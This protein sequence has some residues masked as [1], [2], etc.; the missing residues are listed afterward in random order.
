[1]SIQLL[2]DLNEAQKKAVLATEGPL[3]IL[4]GAGSG[5][6]RVLT[7][8]VAYL[9]LEK[10]VDPYN[11]LMVTFT[12]KAAGE[13]KKRIQSLVGE[14]H[15]PQS[16]T[17]HAFAAKLLRIEGN[18][19]GI[20]KSFS[21]YDEQDQLEAIKRVLVALDISSKNFHPKSLANTISQAKNELINAHEYVQYARG[22]FQETASRVYLAYQE[23][24]KKNQALDFDD[25][26]LETVR[27]LREVPTVAQKYQERFHYVLVDE[28]QD[29]N[30]AQY[31]ITRLLSKKHRNVCIVGDASQS[32]YSWRGANFRNIMNFQKDFPGTK[33][34]HLEQN[35]RSTQK[36]IDA[37]Y[38]VISFNTSHPVLKLWTDNSQGDNII[39]YEARNEQ[40]EAVFI[41]NTINHLLNQKKS[42]I[43]LN[44]VAVLYRTNAQSRV[45][46]E[47]FLH[48]SLPYTL[49]GGVRFYDRKEIKDIL[50]YL[51]FLVN[52]KDSVAFS[53]MGKIG[54]RKFDLYLKL[55]ENL[56]KEGLE[57]YTTLEILDK[58]ISQTDY[59]SLY[60]KDD[61]EDL[62]RLENI[63]E[64]RSVATQFPRL[65]EFLENV[66]LVEQ[67]YLPSGKSYYTNNFADHDKKK[68]VSLMTIHAAKGLEFKIVFLVGL[69]EGLFPHS[70]ALLERDE[71]E[72]ERRLCYVA[73]TRAKDM[74]FL[75]YTRRRLFFGK[76]TNNLPSRF[77]ADIPENLLT[78][79]TEYNPFA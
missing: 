38:K 32:I 75:T 15:I 8:K 31:E 18:S 22:Y 79:R 62:S 14:N 66:A 25:L 17:F 27:L 60:D 64:L 35:Y 39:L 2:N 9:I 30:L 29:T 33:V 44:N 4:A 1:M 52:P 77:L 16:G 63:K 53:R 37:A 54:K 65:T 41:V 51:K 61:A 55:F 6:T 5:K 43:T 3:L 48:N 59:L 26:L 7:Y 57:K 19:I 56:T 70:Q 11:I 58:V 45:I 36:I 49:I 10:K 50:A 28:Y 21:I 23:M 42:G 13:M 69:E 47:A 71:L 20:P 78:F 72:E 46:E 12:N 74:L 40:D 67:E 76:S 34:F 73:I 24:L 68:A